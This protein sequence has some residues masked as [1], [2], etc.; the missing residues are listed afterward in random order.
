MP[1]LAARSEDAFDPARH[2]LER[3]VGFLQARESRTMTH[4]EL[5]RWIFD[6]REK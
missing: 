3:M 1:A 2:S 4:S 5:E 6:A